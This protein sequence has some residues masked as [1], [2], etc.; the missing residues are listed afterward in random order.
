MFANIITRETS[1]VKLTGDHETIDRLIDQAFRTN[2][3]QAINTALRTAAHAKAVSRL[4]VSN[5]EGSGQTLDEKMR[6]M[7]YLGLCLHLGREIHPMAA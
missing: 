7:S 3:S 2:D 5:N 1:P 6:K 4:D